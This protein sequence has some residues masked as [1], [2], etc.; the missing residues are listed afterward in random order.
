MSHAVI[1]LEKKEP[2]LIVIVGPTAVGK[3]ALS[4]NLAQYF[5]AEIISADARQ[6][7]KE[8]EIGTAKPSKSELKTVKHHFVDCK[9][10]SETYSAGDFERDVDA[11]LENYFKTKNIAILC[12]GSGLYIRALLEGLDEMPVTPP[13]IREKL[14]D[15]L[16]S[17]G[18]EKLANEL[19]ELEPNI[20]DIIDI[21]NPQRVVRALEVNL[22]TGQNFGEL[23]KAKTKKLPFRVIKIGL[24]LPREQLY[25]QINSRVD[26]MITAGLINEVEN[27]QAYKNMN[28]LQTVGYSE[29]FCFLE[30]EITFDK[31]VE[32]IKQNTR[33]YAKRQLTWFKNKDTFM[34]FEP[35]KFEE[36]KAYCEKGLEGN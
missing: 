4:I 36:I 33:R 1:N 32:L 21:Q 5:C 23:R 2:T 31:A 19:L 15:R 26:T 29:I 13:H 28:A 9:S 11:F 6:F 16:A 7:F 3:T 30:N 18:L 34:W 27:L 25:R 10:I 17:E 22:Y 14:M 12:G 8:M 24:E 35:E 20:A